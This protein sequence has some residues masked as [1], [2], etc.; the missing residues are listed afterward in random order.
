M[1]DGPDA[2]ARKAQALLPQI[3]PA[4]SGARDVARAAVAEPAPREIV[5]RGSPDEIQEH[6]HEHLSSDGLPVIPPTLAHA[7][8]FLAHTPRAPDEVIGRLLPE[9]RAAAIWSIAD[10]GVT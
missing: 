2:V 8:R 10:N 3:V 4:L 1:A 5:Y 9:N 7:E 6:F